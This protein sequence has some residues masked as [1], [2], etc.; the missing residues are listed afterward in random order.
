MFTDKVS[1]SE[2]H[3]LCSCL[4]SGACSFTWIVK[5]SIKGMFGFRNVALDWYVAGLIA[6][7]NSCNGLESRLQCLSFYAAVLN[8]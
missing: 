5:R 1:C 6:A 2:A 4:K 7:M 3:I 8:K